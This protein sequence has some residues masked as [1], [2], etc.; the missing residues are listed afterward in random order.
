MRDRDRT[1]EPEPRSGPRWSDQA[2]QPTSPSVG[3]KPSMGAHPAVTSRRCRRRRP[4]GT[5]LSALLAPFPRGPPYDR[6]PPKGGVGRRDAARGDDN[7]TAGH[8]FVPGRLD[9]REPSRRGRELVES[10]R[11]G[12]ERATRPAEPNTALVRHP[13]AVHRPQDGWV[14][15][16]PRRLLLRS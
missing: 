4:G 10:P 11:R 8:R 12:P 6:T 14:R 16:L 5:G 9:L 13:A 2:P 15:L 3:R 1:R 7:A